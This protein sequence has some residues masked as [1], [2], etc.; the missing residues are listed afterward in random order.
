MV[1]RLALE[2]LGHECVFASE[3]DGHLREVYSENFPEGPPISGDIRLS[4][5]GMCLRHDLLWR[6]ISLPAFLGSRRGARLV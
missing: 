3:I 2:R 6:R 5:G 1:F 4:K